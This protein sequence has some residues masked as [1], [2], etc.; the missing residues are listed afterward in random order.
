MD[1]IGDTGFGGIG[2]KTKTLINRVS[3]LKNSK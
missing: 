2:V 1:K 3:Y